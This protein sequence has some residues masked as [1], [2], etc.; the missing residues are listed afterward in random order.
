MGALL[1]EPLTRFIVQAIA[2]LGLSRLVGVA[3]RKLRQP[4]AGVAVPHALAPELSPRA[5]LVTLARPLAVPTP[6]GQP[7]RLLF[8]LTFDRSGPA[9]LG[10]LAQAARLA[11]FGTV[12]A[13]VKARDPQQAIRALGADGL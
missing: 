1:H 4:I 3:T 6:D 13:L 8:V 7:L 9:L 2:I 11:A 10:V 12:D 5:V